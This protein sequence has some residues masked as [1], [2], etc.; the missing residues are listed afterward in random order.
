MPEPLTLESLAARV[1]A[2]ERVALPPGVIPLKNGHYALPGMGG[3]D[4]AFAA[5]RKLAAT[6]DFTAF[7]AQEEFERDAARRELP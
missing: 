6:Y 5:F 2:L 1:E 7:D 3:W 4:A